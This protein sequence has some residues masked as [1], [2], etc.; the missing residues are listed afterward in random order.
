MHFLGYISHYALAADVI[1]INIFA[2]NVSCFVVEV[3]AKNNNTGFVICLWCL[4][5]WRL[6]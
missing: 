5:T 3:L 6:Y 2:F 4:V 1:I